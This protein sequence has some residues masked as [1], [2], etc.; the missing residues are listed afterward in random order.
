[1]AESHKTNYRTRS[2]AVVDASAFVTYRAYISSG[3]DLDL[4]IL[5]AFF[6]QSH[7]TTNNTSKSSP[8]CIKIV[9]GLIVGNI[10]VRISW[11]KF[12]YGLRSHGV[13]IF[14]KNIF[15]DDLDFS[16][17]DLQKLISSWSE[18]TKYL[19]NM[20]RSTP[21]TDS[22]ATAFTRFFFGHHWLWSKKILRPTAF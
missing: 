9:G 16:T 2:G 3:R 18:Y 7:R 17:D 6:L 15:S 10:R 21:F 4:W 8:G 20:F 5:T 13:H 22:G 11:L 1:M 14:Q 19:C 12:I